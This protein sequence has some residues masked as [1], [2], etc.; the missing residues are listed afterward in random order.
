M[1]LV[2]HSDELFKIIDLNTNVQAIAAQVKFRTTVTICN[3]YSAA[4]QELNRQQQE[5][6]YQQRP[7]SCLILGDINSLNP[8]WA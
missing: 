8:A 6:L 4:S 5:T 2:S 7:H 3:I 1:P